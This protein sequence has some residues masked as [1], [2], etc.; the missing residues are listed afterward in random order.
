MLDCWKIWKPASETRKETSMPR[1]DLR[2]GLDPHAGLL[3]YLEAAKGDIHDGT[4]QPHWDKNATSG[5]DHRSWER[6]PHQKYSTLCNN[7]MRP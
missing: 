3:E 7:P 5:R 1:L 6:L 2:P 4:R